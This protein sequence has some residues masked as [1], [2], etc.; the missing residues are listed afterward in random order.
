MGDLESLEQ[1]VQQFTRGKEE[2]GGQ[3]VCMCVCVWE[4]WV[5]HCL[6][7]RIGRPR[8]I[9]AGKH[10]FLAAGKTWSCDYSDFLSTLSATEAK[11]RTLPV[12]PE[13]KE[14][15]TRGFSQ[16]MSGVKGVSAG[17]LL[18]T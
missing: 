11:A 14:M 18:Q 17:F 9:L 3:G 15:P 8:I 10:L 5:L 2:E 7:V 6:C 13:L 12:N 4:G 16:E 1:N